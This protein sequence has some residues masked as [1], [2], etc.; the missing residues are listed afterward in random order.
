M[1]ADGRVLSA[2]PPLDGS[3]EARVATVSPDGATLAVTTSRGHL[4]FV[5]T[6]DGSRRDGCQ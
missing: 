3:G 5:S 4:T 1:H 6:S 2:L